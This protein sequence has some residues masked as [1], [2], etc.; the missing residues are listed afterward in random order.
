[1]MTDASMGEEWRIALFLRTAAPSTHI[2]NAY[3]KLQNHFFLI[4]HFRPIRVLW[5]LNSEQML[6]WTATMA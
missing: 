2:S 1:M 3:F 6:D 4:W 5:P